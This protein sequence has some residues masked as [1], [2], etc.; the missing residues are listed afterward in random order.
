MLRIVSLIASG[1]EIIAAL[2]CED[3]LVARSHECDFPP[4]IQALPACTAKKIDVTANSLEIDVEIKKIVADGLSIYDVDAEQLKALKPDIIVTQ[5][6]CDVCAISEAQLQVAV[7]GWID[8][9]TKIISLAPNGLD[10]IW[11]DIQKVADAIGV[12]NRGATLI[13][14]LS[15]RLSDIEAKTATLSNQPSVVCIEWISPLM[16]A[17]NWVPE[18]VH[19]AG[20]INLL[21]AAGK[22]SP[23]ME[24]TALQSANPD[25]ILIIPCGFKIDRSRAEI[26]ALTALPG[27]QSLTAVHRSQTFIA[28]GNQY[29]NRP[30]PRIIDSTEILAEIL[31][32]QNFSFGHHQSG[33][34]KL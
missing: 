33:W 14:D 5:S 26:S 8:H 15:A 20:G 21:G 4:A 11:A 17:G 23:W 2:G 30:G 34:Q 32:P 3:Q 29:F 19:L 31:H 12:S 25:I 18:L 10:D 24:W 9:H 16:A 6:Q 1:T 27:W 13:S 7:A 28:D 22:H